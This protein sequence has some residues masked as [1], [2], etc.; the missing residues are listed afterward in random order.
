MEPANRISGLV[1]K[2][3]HKPG[4]RVVE[5]VKGGHRYSFRYESTSEL[6][7]ICALLS[8]AIDPRLNLDLDD[9]CKLMEALGLGAPPSKK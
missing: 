1:A 6:T 3:S 8:A 4:T 2:K 5:F 7:L 9:A